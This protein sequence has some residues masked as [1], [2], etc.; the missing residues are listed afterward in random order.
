MI[1][2]LYSADNQIEDSW[3]VEQKL[4]H[5]ANHCQPVVVDFFEWCYQQRQRVDLLPNNPLATALAYVSHREQALKEFL[6]DPAIS[7]D[8]NHLERGLRVIPKGRKNW[9][10][11]WTEVGAKYVGII[12]SLI[13]TCRLQDVNPNVY[14]TDVLQRVTTYSK[15]DMIEL[16]PRLW[17]E[18]FAENPLLSD[19][20]KL[21]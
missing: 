21:K 4:V 17:K 3:S 5:R 18:K 1:A 20:N 8:T 6:T 11:C 13:V 16:T 2:Q 10:F 12:Q 9:L 7:L 14:L 15:D 19:L